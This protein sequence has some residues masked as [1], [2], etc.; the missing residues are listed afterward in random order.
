M[1]CA[2]LQYL[3]AVH[4]DDSL[5]KFLS[6]VGVNNVVG[7][8]LSYVPRWGLCIGMVPRDGA[9]ESVLVLRYVW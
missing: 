4:Q 6:W 5:D 8:I 3:A 1:R 7:H 2:T 9:L